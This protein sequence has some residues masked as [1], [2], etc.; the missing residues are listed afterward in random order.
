M[1]KEAIFRRLTTPRGSIWG[2]EDYGF[3]IASYVGAVGF[4]TAAAALPSVVEAEVLKDDRIA[5]CATTT[6]IDDD[7]A[8]ITLSLR[9]KPVSEA[10]NFSLTLAVSNVTVSVLGA[11]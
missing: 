3:D 5:A 4:A 6:A 8:S 1:L 10:D 7:A 2:D 9:C 11:L